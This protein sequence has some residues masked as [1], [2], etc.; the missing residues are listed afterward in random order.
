MATA[1]T[2]RREAT[3]MA[4]W[5]SLVVVTPLVQAAKRCYHVDLRLEKR[6]VRLSTGSSGTSTY[7]VRWRWRCGTCYSWQAGVVAQASQ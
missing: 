3:T 1:M 2:R 6:R 4:H 7:V 5:K